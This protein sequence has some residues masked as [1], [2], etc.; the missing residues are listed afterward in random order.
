MNHTNMHMPRQAWALQPAGAQKAVCDVIVRGWTS[1]LQTEDITDILR[2][3]R[4]VSEGG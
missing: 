2:N 4:S 3:H 1:W